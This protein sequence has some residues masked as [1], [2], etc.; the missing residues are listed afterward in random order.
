MMTLVRTT[1]SSVAPTTALSTAA[2]QA[3]NVNIALLG[4]AYA[5][6]AISASPASGVNDGVIGGASLLGLGGL[7]KNEWV[8]TTGANSW[9]Q[10]NFTSNYLIKTVVL[11]ART[12]TVATQ[13][14]AGTLTFSDG[15]SVDTGAIATSGTTV[16]LPTGG[17][18]VHWVR[19]TATK[20]TGVAGLAEMQIYNYAPPAATASQCTAG[21]LNLGGLLC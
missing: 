4:T 10:L 20:V 12:N 7:A 14:T 17:I 18:T 19:F 9:V 5:S 8:S 21:L 11:H 6:S 13:V 15:T 3:T 2:P 16:V 1:S